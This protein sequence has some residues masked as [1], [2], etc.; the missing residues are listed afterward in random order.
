MVLMTAAS[1]TLA[2]K[3][4]GLGTDSPHKYFGIIT[5]SLVLLMGLLGLMRQCIMPCCCNLDWKTHQL[6]AVKNA[7]KYLA[8]MVIIGSQAT[9]STGLLCY[10]SLVD[11]TKMGYVVLGASNFLFYTILVACEVVYRMR[12]KQV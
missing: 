7:H 8:Y 5:L 12:R 11:D 10:F 4:G 3:M 2:I 6:V 9:V 1:A